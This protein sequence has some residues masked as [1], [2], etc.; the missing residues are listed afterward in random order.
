MDDKLLKLYNSIKK[1]SYNRLY[2]NRFCITDCGQYNTFAI[3]KSSHIIGHCPITIRKGCHNHISI[4]DNGKFN[5]L[6][7]TIEGNN[8]HIHIA[9]NVKFS[10]YL[11]IVGNNLSIEI[12]TKTTAIDCYIL[13]RDKSV[14][15]GSE[16]MISRGIEIRATD[17]HKVYDLQS[18]QRLNKATHDIHIGQHVWIAANVTI[19][20][21]VHIADGCII[22]A[23]TFVN[24]SVDT[25][26]CVIAGIPAKIVKTGIYWER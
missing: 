17:V 19:S 14:K 12:A 5:Q 24:K 9:D 8:N 11:L 22:A 16:C 1:L 23:G 15:I 21:N 26:N 2:K 20:K 4:G 25:P 6:K 7:I 3:E 18:K 13:A 10:G